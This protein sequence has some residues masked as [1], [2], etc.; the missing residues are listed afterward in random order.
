MPLYYQLPSDLKEVDI[1]IAGGPSSLS[2]LGLPLELTSLPG[3]TSASVLAGRL[4]TT[5]PNLSILVV[6]GGR[7]NRSL[8]TVAHPALFPL[9]LLPE[10]GTAIF[11]QCEPSEVLA[12]RRL[13]VE[14]GGVLGGGSSI[15]FMV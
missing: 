11:W 10:T 7:D 5:A 12:G 3:G 8:P 13:V 2:A 15:N 9:N 4:A 6:E 1:I 14:S